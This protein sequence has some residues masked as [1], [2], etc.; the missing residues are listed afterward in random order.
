MADQQA[1]TLP[2][3][4]DV[5]RT[6]SQY[7]AGPLEAST[8]AELEEINAA[9]P[10]DAAGRMTSQICLALAKN[11]DAGNRKGRAIANEANQLAL[12]LASL[13]PGLDDENANES[14]PADVRILFELGAVPVEHGDAEVRDEA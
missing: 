8:I 3:F 4:G 2:L 10:L 12:L 7:G 14:I 5:S 9:D 11:I 1:E 6:N 13:R